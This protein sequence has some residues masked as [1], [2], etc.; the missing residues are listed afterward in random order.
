MVLAAFV[1][2]LIFNLSK[3]K[4]FPKAVLAGLAGTFA[5]YLIGLP[6]LYLIKDL[7]LHS[8]IAINI[9]FINCFLIFLP[10][11]IATMVLAAFVSAKLRKLNIF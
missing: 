3:K 5:V 2:G 9:L 4:T 1:T 6:Y 7:Y 11:D 8:P 10:G